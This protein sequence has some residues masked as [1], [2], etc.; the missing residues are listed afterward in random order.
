MSVDS[1]GISVCATDSLYLVVSRAEEMAALVIKTEGT[2]CE[3]QMDR[4]TVH[5]LRDQ[6]PAVLAGLNGWAAETE[7]CLAVGAARRQAVDVAARAR[8]VA[9]AV[10]QAGEPTLAASLRRLANDAS[11]KTTAVEVAVTAFEDAAVEVDGAAHRL[12]H[13]TGE[14]ED[15]LRGLRGTRPA[16]R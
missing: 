1:L 9:L 8:E 13:L 11:A 5:A 6:L 7:R 14:A 12:I 16:H 2:H 10:E 4:A 3:I 15:F